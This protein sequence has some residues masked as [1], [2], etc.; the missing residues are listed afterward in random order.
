MLKEEETY[1]KGNK[2]N[3]IRVYF[4][5]SNGLAILNEFKNLF[6]IIFAAYFTLGIQNPIWIG[7]MAVVGLIGL[8]IV[9]YFSVHH[10]A[11][12]KEW[13]AV[14]FGTHFGIQNFDYVK[15]QTEL[16]EEINKKTK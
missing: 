14:R 7:I 1:L 6:L 16:L 8:T 15:R 10:I 9:G 5:L 13:L 4:Y 3:M 12:I 11:R 2:N